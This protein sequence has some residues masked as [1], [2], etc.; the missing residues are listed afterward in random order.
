[1]DM[2]IC[3]HCGV[4]VT[5]T[6]EGTCPTCDR[7]LLKSTSSPDNGNALKTLRASVFQGA[8]FCPGVGFAGLGWRRTAVGAYLANL[9]ALLFCGWLIIAPK[10]CMFWVVVAML[11][12]LLPLWIYELVLVQRAK[13]LHPPVSA[14]FRRRSLATGLFCLGAV[15][16][17]VGLVTRYQSFTMAGN[18]MSPTLPNGGRLT[19]ARKVDPDR[20]RAG[21]VIAFKNPSKS[22][23][24][25]PGWIVIAR[26]LAVPGDKLSIRHDRYFINGNANAPAKSDGP[27][28]IA[29][30]IPPAP[31]T[32]E[33]P[34][35][36]YFVVQ[37]DAKAFDSRTFSWITISDIV[38]TELYRMTWQR[39]LDKLE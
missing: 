3:P 30:E 21:L 20:L 18:G 37:D 9:I 31:S 2:Q 12:I 10:P 22:A 35:S 4:C 29:L 19:I 1:M 5:A 39:P 36:C 13:C 16:V 14:L 33:V 34:G 7:S 17:L 8:M 25:K 32:A 23:W 38:S 27:R 26:I 24:G 6:A 28:P 11:A 15:F